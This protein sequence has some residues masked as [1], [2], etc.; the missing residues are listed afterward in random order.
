[1]KKHILTCALAMCVFL[2]TV[3]GQETT[4][5]EYN[6]GLA[7]IGHFEVTPLGSIFVGLPDR[8]VMLDQYTG[9]ALWERDD[10]REC[11]PRADD[12]ETS[13]NEADG[14][15]RCEVRGMEFSDWSEIFVPSEYQPWDV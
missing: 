10:I 1:M 3:F 13:S 2:P 4:L 5:W 7:Q 12:P 9:E 8:V 11:Q 15:I 14:T 6:T